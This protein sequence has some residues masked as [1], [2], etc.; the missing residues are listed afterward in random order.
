VV[1]PFSSRRSPRQRR[2]IHVDLHVSAANLTWIIAA[3][4]LAIRRIGERAKRS[5]N[6]VAAPAR[7]TP[8]LLP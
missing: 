5:G 7:L 4:E 6:A 3:P 2:K 1:A 8:D